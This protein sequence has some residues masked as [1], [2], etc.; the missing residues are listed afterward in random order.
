MEICQVFYS[1]M[2]LK[3]KHIQIQTQIIYTYRATLYCF[4][5]MVATDHHLQRL[6]ARNSQM[7]KHC[8]RKMRRN[9]VPERLC[10]KALGN[11][12]RNSYE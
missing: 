9:F 12:T 8:D 6:R 3:E 2:S 11:P 4:L 1:L 5:S 7:G 10:N